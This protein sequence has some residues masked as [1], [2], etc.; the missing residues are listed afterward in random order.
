MVFMFMPSSLPHPSSQ[1]TESCMPSCSVDNYHAY[2]IL[3]DWR[4]KGKSAKGA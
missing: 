4:R 2:A 3:C 1:Q